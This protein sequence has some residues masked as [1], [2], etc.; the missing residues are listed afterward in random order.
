M[1]MHQVVY[2]S[3]V[4]ENTKRF[5][6]KLDIDAVRIP[7][8]QKLEIPQVDKPFVLI[9]PTYGTT[10]ADS[11][12]PKQ[13]IKFLN[14]AH[15]RALL[16]GVIASGNTNFGSKYCHAGKLVADKCN[17]PLLYKFELIGTK[18]DVEMV[19]ERMEN[20]WTQF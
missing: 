18:Y 12:I 8:N 2:F 10:D 20:L 7:L 14:L 11:G 6:E 19:T 4:S 3:N 9:T 15:N 17:V 16:K 13:V 5:V 1:T